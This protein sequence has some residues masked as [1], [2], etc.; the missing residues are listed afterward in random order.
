VEL[1]VAAL[2]DITNYWWTI[3]VGLCLGIFVGTIPGFSS[4]NTLIMLL[5]FTLGMRPEVGLALMASIYTGMQL[6]GG[7]PAILFNV[8]GNPGAAATCL[9]GYAMNQQGKT[10]QALV[11]AI[12]CSGIAGVL[13]SAAAVALLPYLRWAAFF[14]GT[15]ENFIII[16]FGVSL[17]A[18]IGGDVPIK[19]YLA[20]MLGLLIG[21]I[22]YDHVFSIPRATFGILYLF[23][24]PPTIAVLVG[25]FA[26]S[27]VMIM[28]EKFSIQKH[29]SL[30]PVVNDWASTLEGMKILVKNKWT[31][32]RSS[33]IG[34]IIGVIPGAGASIASWVSY[35]QTVALASTEEKATFGKGN[36]KGVIA[37]ECGNS[38]IT[39][40]ALIPMITIG[41]PGGASTA[42]MLIV[43]QSHGVP[44][45][46][47][48]FQVNPIM[49][50]S[51]V[52]VMLL[53]DILMLF[54]GLP[55]TRRLTRVTNIPKLILIPCI[56]SF[57]LIGAFVGRRFVF[58]MGVAVFFG[59]IGYI[60]KKTG[61]P[62]HCLLL[63]VI[64]GP[65]TETHFLRAI[66]LGRGDISIF[67]RNTLGNVLWLLLI[68]SMFG[69]GLYEKYKKKR[70]AKNNI[71]A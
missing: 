36:P 46:P 12:M 44:V 8:P 27:E 31:V 17:I 13:S 38:A 35:Q 42:V 56:V 10:N 22:G 6:G 23:D 2:L 48:L 49:A 1:F 57:V 5:P 30:E 52:I 71:A 37:A 21:A 26:I 11:L 58:D 3:P 50:Y 15:I 9:D 63:G 14:F 54:I 18:Q 19:G 67:F 65:L 61:Y 59:V 47:R 69:P 43:M 20:G 40:G 39:A 68:V 28:A 16:L 53:A 45:G 29:Q 70:A 34:F 32:I 64:L 60:M 41:I 51:V 55:L 33:I 24:G 25:L 66:Q 7:V 4:S 62:I